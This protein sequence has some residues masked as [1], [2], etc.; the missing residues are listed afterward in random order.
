MKNDHPKIVA[1][2]LITVS[3]L[4]QMYLVPSWTLEVMYKSITPNLPFIY[5]KNLLIE[6][7]LYIMTNWNLLHKLIEES[8]T[9]VLDFS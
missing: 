7:L 8:G 4:K 2:Y 6:G 3:F 5:T 1:G 9:I